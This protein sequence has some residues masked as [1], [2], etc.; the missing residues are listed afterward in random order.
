MKR[1]VGRV[2]L[3]GVD[4]VSSQR[5]LLRY[6]IFNPIKYH[7]LMV[8]INFHCNS[9]ET[10]VLACLLLVKCPQRTFLGPLRHQSLTHI[11][12][13]RGD[14]VSPAIPLYLGGGAENSQ[15][16][17]RVLPW[18]TENDGVCLYCLINFIHSFLYYKTF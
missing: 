10:C 12:R 3:E 4:Y 1:G 13:E 9:S 5:G 8:C 17:V 11:L 2:E 16:S 15:A 18:A 6:R 7:R 14:N